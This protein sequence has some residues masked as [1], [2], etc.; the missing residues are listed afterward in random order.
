MTG[1]ERISR[2]LKRQKVDRSGFW[3]GNPHADALKIYL[4]AFQV[5]T[6]EELSA[7]LRNDLVWIN[8]EEAVWRSALPYLDPLGGKKR[9][10][11]NQDGIFADCEDVHEVDTAYWPNAS[12]F[13]FDSL[14]SRFAIAKAQQV[15]VFSGMWS[16]FWHQLTDYFGMENCFVK[17]YSDPEV[18]TAVAEHLCDFHLQA[19]RIF[20]DRYADDIDVFFFG[21]DLG[22]QIDTLISPEMFQKFVLPYV[23]KLI[24]LAKS[25]GLKVAFHSCGS[26]IRFIPSLIDAGVD[27]LH[28]VQAR[29]AHMDA[30]NLKSRFGES[31]VFMGGLDTQDILPFGNC[32]SVREEVRRLRGI[33]GNNFILSPSH[34]ALL[35]NVS[36]ENVLAMAKEAVHIY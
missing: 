21:N 23:K 12:N 3:M 4:S 29:A 13:D 16:P 8:G 7:K 6:L 1:K 20:F 17:M 2:I 33:F 22:S 14:Q 30:V 19:N 35:K 10:S 15:A 26:I 32:E 24:D 34:E 28:P 11:L 31:V 9:C 36:P 18:V 25:Y 27:I 5:E